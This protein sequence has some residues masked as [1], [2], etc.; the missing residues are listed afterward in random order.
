[1]NQAEGSEWTPEELE[2]TSGQMDRVREIE[3]EAHPFMG[4]EREEAA[5]QIS[6]LRQLIDKM[7]GENWQEQYQNLKTLL[8]NMDKIDKEFDNQQIEQAA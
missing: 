5:E 3:A 4:P 1:M 2:G 6:L 7:P 8:D